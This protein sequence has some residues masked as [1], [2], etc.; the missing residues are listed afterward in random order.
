MKRSNSRLKASYH[1]H[2]RIGVWLCLPIVLVAITGVLLNHSEFFSFDSRLVSTSA[3]LDWYGMEPKSEPI[4]LRAETNWATS[5]D[6]SLYV[7]GKHIAQQV[8]LL[9]GFVDFGSTLVVSSDSHAYLIE[10]DSLLL[11][12]KLGSE[13][14]PSGQIISSSGD[15]SGIH[16]D[17][18]SGQYRAEKDL[19]S[20]VQEERAP[21]PAAQRSV[22]NEREY[23]SVLVDWRGRG[24][25][26]TRVLRD[27]HTGRFFGSIG[28]FIVDLAGIALLLLAGTGLYNVWKLK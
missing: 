26:M 7:N 21:L 15:E 23:Q 28:V 13:S 17:T 1:W 27:I 5:L 14:L 10:K 2:R 11:I 4:V 25:S 20:F 19:V 16:I 3:I 22:L 8:P 9:T 24:L 6:G 18:T 12:E